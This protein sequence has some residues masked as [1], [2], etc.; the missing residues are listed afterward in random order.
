MRW[1]PNVH[2]NTAAVHFHD[3]P[4][5]IN[6]LHTSETLVESCSPVSQDTS[7]VESALY[8]TGMP[9]FCSGIIRAQRGLAL[10]AVTN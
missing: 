2:S 10:C 8:L 3:Q 6:V 4:L 7:L 9:S 1:V 5:A